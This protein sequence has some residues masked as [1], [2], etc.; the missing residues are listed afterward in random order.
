MVILALKV[1]ILNLQLGYTKLGSTQVRLGLEAF[2][3]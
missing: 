1:G 3:K 2:G